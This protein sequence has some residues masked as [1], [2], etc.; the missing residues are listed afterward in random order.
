LVPW[1]IGGRINVVAAAVRAAADAMVM[2][3]AVIPS[4]ACEGGHVRLFVNY[5][6]LRSFPDHVLG[7][8]ADATRRFDTECPLAAHLAA[9]FA[10]RIRQARDEGNA[11]ERHARNHLC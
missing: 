5:R 6:L 2:C 7:G 1:H 11:N 9:D 8:L 3:I 10:G 4:Q